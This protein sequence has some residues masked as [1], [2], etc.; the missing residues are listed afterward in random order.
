MF[1]E[2]LSKL[3]GAICLAVWMINIGHFSDP[4]HGGLF[5]GAI[6]YFKIAVALAVAAV[7]EGLPA[8]V[9]TCLALGTRQMAKEG[10]IVRSLPSVETLGCT[11]AICVDKTGT[12]TTNQ[13]CVK[14]LFI[15]KKKE[16]SIAPVELAVDGEDYTPF[17][18]LTPAQNETYS[19][20]SLL[21]LAACASICNDSK[22]EYSAKD[23][24]FT[25]IGEPTEAALQVLVEK[26]GTTPASESVSSTELQ[27]LLRMGA[28]KELI[29]SKANHCGQYWARLYEKLNTLEFTRKR[30]S[31]G[32]I[33]LSKQTNERILFVK[34]APEKLLQRCST[35]EMDSG[36]IIEL[37]D[38]IK[39]VVADKINELGSRAY[40]CLA[41]TKGAAPSENQTVLDVNN[42]EHFEAIEQRLTLIGIV[43][44]VD[45]VRPAVKDAVKACKAAGIRVIV[46]TG[47]NH[48]TAA[49]VCHKLGILEKYETD[50]LLEE[51]EGQAFHQY[52]K[53]MSGSDWSYLSPAEKDEVAKSVVLL[54]RVEPIHKFEI[55]K[56]LKEAGETLAFIGDGVNDAPALKKADIGVAMGSGTAVAKEA[57]DLILLDDNFGTIVSAVKYGRSI[58]TNTKQFI[59]YLI[60]SNI[61]EV[62]C[63][64]FAAA[65]GI[66]EALTPVQ[67]LWVNFV[68]DGLPATALSFN[69]PEKDSMKKPPRRREDGLVDSFTF[70]RYAVVGIY[71]GVA[72]VLGFL[73]WFMIF[74][75]GPQLTFSQLTS[76]QHCALEE[77]RVN[78]DFDCS[79]FTDAEKFRYPSTVALSILVTIEML[80]ALNSISETQ[81]LTVITP[82]SNYLLIG[83]IA[84]SFAL[85]FCILYI[86]WLS[87]IFGVAPL[88]YSEWYAVISF[89]APVIVID[90]LI[91][92]YA[93]NESLVSGLS[94]LKSMKLSEKLSKQR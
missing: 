90:E 29:S 56:K 85:H 78:L 8:V 41:L 54:S 9:T 23:R 42:S 22:I 82:F 91:K 67:L 44:M 7:P 40:R 16:K 10:A 48:N 59:R 84:L 19:K 11:T 1:G 75:N 39:A 6:Y 66:P 14:S 53:T 71:V 76:F 15:W 17:G 60:S 26:I 52:N 68:T 77:E 92:F 50:T 83:A 86:R 69:K 88:S 81:S 38:E 74:E 58:Y 61:G 65:L 27:N 79:T 46:L 70:F 4:A 21:D 3:I 89:S 37:N 43:G 87:D 94:S 12:L 62:C 51:L 33:C 80:N 30:K 28:S 35:I 34:G 72:V 36:E 2:Q 73:W 47:D 18:E 93:R 64:F 63:I 20:K 45:P 13:M 25:R 5:K 24:R 55:V 32:V 31:M 49:A 57:S